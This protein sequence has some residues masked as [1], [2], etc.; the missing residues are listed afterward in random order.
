MAMEGTL[1]TPTSPGLF[2]LGQGEKLLQK[3]GFW[4]TYFGEMLGSYPK[5][6]LRKFNLLV[7]FVGKSLDSRKVKV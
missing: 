4:V 5:L 6:I 1:H 3:L 7:G 2:L